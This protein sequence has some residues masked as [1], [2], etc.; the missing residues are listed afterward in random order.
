MAWISFVYFDFD[1]NL[2]ASRPSKETARRAPIRRVRT[3][4]MADAPVG[5]RRRR[6]TTHYAQGGEAFRPQGRTNGK[7][8]FEFYHAMKHRRRIGNDCCPNGFGACGQRASTEQANHA[9]EK[10]L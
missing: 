4:T 1:G 10:P 6:A 7:D 9:R 5:I 8:S 2:F 3:R